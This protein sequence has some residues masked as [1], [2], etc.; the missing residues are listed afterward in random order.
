MGRARKLNERLCA[1]IEV[2]C[3]NTDNG[4]D[5]LLQGLAWL[6]EE[7]TKRKSQYSEKKTTKKKKVSA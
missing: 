5:R 6:S 3:D 4:I 2:S 7:I 1:F